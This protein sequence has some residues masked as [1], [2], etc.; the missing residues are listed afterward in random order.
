VLLPVE[1]PAIVLAGGWALLR[2]VR[3]G[4]PL[5]IALVALTAAGLMLAWLG[6]SRIG[7]NNDL[8]WRAALPAVLVLTA[9]AAAALSDLIAARARI[10]ALA[11]LV[12]LALGLVDG[13]LDLHGYA[14]AGGAVSRDFA[15]DAAMWQAVRRHAGP[16]DRVAS[17]PQL[18][19]GLT[20]WP[21]N[22][23]WALLGDRRSC[24][25]G[26]EMALAFAALPAPRRDAID[27]RFRRIFAGFASP[28]D[29]E[30]LFRDYG[31]RVVLV[32][33]RD[34]AW[35]RD[36]FA[37]SADYRLAETRP[38]AWRIYAPADR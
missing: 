21:V 36:P 19:A 3:R 23:S 33:A 15:T 5:V 17:N 27:E 8:A 26:R 6:Q 31:C 11:G 28:A 22:I 35:L 16:E 12:A 37:A 13:L 32:T 1:F 9:A 4:A 7:D 29:I 38:G 14:T 30:A 25:A 24:F 2:R 20:P 34:G 10:A 18:E